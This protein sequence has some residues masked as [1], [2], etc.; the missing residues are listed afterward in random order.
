VRRAS[1][2]HAALVTA[3]VAAVSVGL[4]GFGAR[5]AFAQTPEAEPREAVPTGQD[6]DVGNSEWNGLS[7]LY[8]VLL[9]AGRE[10]AVSPIVNLRDLPLEQP[11][12]LVHP[13]SDLPAAEL[14]QWVEAGGRLLVADDF[15]SAD[16]LMRA[17][18]VR[19]LAGANPHATFY[20]ENPA[21]PLFGDVAEHPVTDGVSLVWGNHALALRS[22]EAPLIR[23]DLPDY[24]LLYEVELGAG[25]AL[26]LGDPSVLI[27][28][29]FELPDNRTLALNLVRRLCE[30]REP[31]TVRLVTGA[32]P[33]VGDFPEPPRED[34][35]RRGQELFDESFELVNERLDRLRLARPSPRG[36]Y[37][38][39]LLFALG[40]A[41]FLF[42]AL[43]LSPPKWLT[44]SLRGP[45]GARSR[46]EFEWNL[47][48]LLRDGAEGD[49][50]LPLSILKD[51]FE[52]LFF[53]ALARDP[54]ELA[55]NQRYQPEQLQRFASRFA[56]KAFP[57]ASRGRQ[58]EAT[59]RALETLT[60][61]A[62][63]P[64]RTSLVPEVD[65]RYSER[66]FRRVFAETRR[67]L[68]EIGLFGRY[69]QRTHRP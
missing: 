2:A 26:V 21:L 15:G 64:P 65:A 23:W 50:A 8:R 57:E 41:A 56:A 12:L 37:V 55:E 16:P 44:F 46:S 6:Y 62:S 14:V 3:L 40:V 24:G 67:L 28:F 47:E 13:T 7:E 58:R 63:I 66:L 29:M 45:K 33:L 31:C 69:E 25:R 51:E 22:E 4:T 20:R 61:L 27:N 60:L 42:S 35:L 39:S 11:L 38:A 9:L 1:A 30:G 32:T 54:S 49:Y 43:P 68:V 18:G 36:V 53:G 48:R 5:P 59:Q 17:L 10:I 34:R 19:P 52:E